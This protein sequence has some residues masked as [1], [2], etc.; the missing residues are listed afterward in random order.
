MYGFNV[1]RDTL[2]VPCLYF[3]LSPAPLI[4]TK[5]LKVPISLL[6]GLQIRVMIYLNDMLIML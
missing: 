4:F 6:R 2:R 5:I 3:G 1:G